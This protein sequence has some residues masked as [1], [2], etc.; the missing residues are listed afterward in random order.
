[1][2]MKNFLFN[3]GEVLFAVKK[4]YKSDYPYFGFVNPLKVNPLELLGLKTPSKA[5]KFK[6]KNLF[7]GEK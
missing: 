1:M 4:P 2:K 6:A 7:T 3:K 5:R